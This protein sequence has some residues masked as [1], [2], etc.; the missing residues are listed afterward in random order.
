MVWLLAV[1]HGR[2]AV[3]GWWLVEASVEATGLG[4][5]IGGGG[6]CVR[7]GRL[8]GG[9]VGWVGGAVVEEAVVA[10]DVVAMVVVAVAAGAKL[11]RS[12]AFCI[13]H[14]LLVGSSSTRVCGPSCHRARETWQRA[15]PHSLPATI[16]GTSVVPRTHARPFGP[17][18]S[19][20]RPR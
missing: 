4:V 18:R 17:A 14:G 19:P 1:E 13:G 2:V 3:G 10:V 5:K 9:W 7:V 16:L 15:S 8:S 20:F 11:P 12:P 6:R